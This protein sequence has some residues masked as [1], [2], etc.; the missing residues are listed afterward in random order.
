[1]FSLCVSPTWLHCSTATYAPGSNSKP[2]S[3]PAPTRLQN[4][5]II[6]RMANWCNS[7]QL[8]MGPAKTTWNV[9]CHPEL[10]GNHPALLGLEPSGTAWT[11]LTL[12][13]NLQEVLWQWPSVS[14]ARSTLSVICHS[15]FTLYGNVSPLHFTIDSCFIA[16]EQRNMSFRITTFHSYLILWLSLSF[17]ACFPSFVLLIFYIFVCIS[18]AGRADVVLGGICVCLCQHRHS[19]N[20]LF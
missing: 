2:D 7:A 20:L 1:M 9:Q 4:D 3:S 18:C 16:S 17:S 13:R 14:R 8:A 5:L 11:C 15:C 10:S 19:K 6:C 12:Y